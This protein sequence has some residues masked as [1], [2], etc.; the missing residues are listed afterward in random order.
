MFTINYLP[1]NSVLVLHY[2]LLSTWCGGFLQVVYGQ[3]V[4]P[5]VSSS[6][7][8]TSSLH[9]RPSVMLYIKIRPCVE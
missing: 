5:K 9:S 3:D 7:S 4:F 6:T 1:V 8:L 2:S